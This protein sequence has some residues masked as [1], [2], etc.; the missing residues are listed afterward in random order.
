M[1][2]TEIRVKGHIDPTWSEWLGGLKI[3]HIDPNQTLLSGVVADQS[4]LFGILIKLRDMGLDI[5]S[6]NVFEPPHI[7]GSASHSWKTSGRFS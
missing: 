6:V 1:Q 4:N 3:S 5:V 7:E 2:N